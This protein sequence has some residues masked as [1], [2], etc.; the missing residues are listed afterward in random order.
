M[1]FYIVA[2]P[3]NIMSQPTYS[4]IIPHYNIPGLLRRL[5]FSIPKRD[6]LQVI[7]VDDCSNK[8]LDELNALK[9]EFDWVE[10]YDTKING[11][12]GKARNIGLAHATGK[13]VLFADADDYFDLRMN[14]ILNKYKESNADLICFPIVEIEQNPAIRVRQ[15]NNNFK[16][17]KLNPD[18]G[19]F[20]IRFA[21][22]CPWGKLISMKL[23][24]NNT[25]NFEESIIHNDVLFS[26]RIGINA[27]NVIVAEEPFYVL[28]ERDN[29]VSK[30]LSDKQY[31]SRLNTYAQLNKM[32]Q[33]NN[34][35]RFDK[36]LFSPIKYYL[37]K[38]KFRKLRRCFKIL[39]ENGITLFDL[40][41]GYL[42]LNKIK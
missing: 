38:F 40:L 26:A 13:Y 7:V 30:V 16:D 41:G 39:N 35:E 14:E 36:M 27:K 8:A 28:V 42:S 11:G 24:K 23:V 18:K 33:A 4:L 15:Y 32:Y 21:Y 2:Q 5:L 6:D 22:L 9:Q 3:C 19:L 12:G 34:I 17:Y 1:Y 20:S 37:K 10:W 25:I 31:Y 29:S